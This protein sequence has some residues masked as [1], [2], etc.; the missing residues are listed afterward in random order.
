[1]ANNDMAVGEAPKVLVVEDEI[2]ARNLLVGYLEEQGWQV[3]TLHSA[4]QVLSSVAEH[5][6]DLVFLDIR[7]PAGDGLS[8]CREIRTRYSA[9]IIFTTAIDDPIERI[10]GLEAGADAYYSKP[11]PMREMI[12]G[13]KALLRRVLQIKR[14]LKGAQVAAHRQYHFGGWRFDAAGQLLSGCEDVSLSHNE[15]VV[16]RALCE[17]PRQP[18]KRDD[19]MRALGKSDWLP[20]DRT[21]D[22]LIGR[23]RS[24]LKKVVPDGANLIS[25]QYGKGYILNADELAVD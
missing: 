12:A 23:I 20:F 1:M 3:D 14:L 11:L 24:K 5:D 25:A 7:L 17:R 8:L 21:L 15:T 13:A 19:L 9:G 10:V 2:T 6:Y 22:V 16:L 18:V 4:E